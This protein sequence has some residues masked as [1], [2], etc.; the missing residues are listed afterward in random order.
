MESTC[1]LRLFT[2][3]LA[4]LE[5]GHREVAPICPRHPGARTRWS[6]FGTGIIVT[7]DARNHLLRMCDREEFRAELKQATEALGR[8]RSAGATVG[9]Y[10]LE[11]ETGIP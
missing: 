6:T 9:E 3:S 8:E 4:E 10:L 11:D 2:W 7:C 1:K 5:T